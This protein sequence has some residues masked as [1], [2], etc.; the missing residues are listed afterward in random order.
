MA[1]LWTFVFTSTNFPFILILVK[2]FALYTNWLVS[3]S[4]EYWSLQNQ[5]S[6]SVLRKRS[7]TSIKQTYRRNPL[8]CNFIE[9][10]LRH[11]CS[12]VNLFHIVKAFAMKTFRGLLLLLKMWV[13][14]SLGA[15]DWDLIRASRKV[16][17]TVINKTN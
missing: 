4:G 6:I 14:E 10:T 16:S 2:S 17:V 9:I 11:G 13:L 3:L 7:S 15:L 8:L 1:F 12:P 5:H